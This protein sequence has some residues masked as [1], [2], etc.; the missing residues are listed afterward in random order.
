MA[1]DKGHGV[2]DLG[3]SLRHLPIGTWLD[4]L[5]PDLVT[6]DSD[7]FWVV[8]S[9]TARQIAVYKAEDGEALPAAAG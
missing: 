6:K 9:V 2:V 7:T 5:L 4:Q 1:R 3:H 8:L